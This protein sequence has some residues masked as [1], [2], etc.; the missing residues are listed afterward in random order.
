M[1]DDEYTDLAVQRLV[2]LSITIDMC[3]GCMILHQHEY[4][5]NKLRQRDIKYG[6]PALPEV[7]E[8]KLPPLPAEMRNT[9]SYTENLK[10]AQDEVGGTPVAGA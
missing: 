2:F 7:E 1:T 4:L 6:R 5:D 9:K 3:P 8:G 10:K